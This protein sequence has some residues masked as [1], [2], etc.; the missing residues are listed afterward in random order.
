MKRFLSKA[1]DL[2]CFVGSPYLIAYNLLN[3]DV[4]PITTKGSES[5]VYAPAYYY[6]YTLGTQIGFALGVSL[7]CLGFLVKA[8]KK[9]SI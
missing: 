5:L 7:V 9:K 6:H 4:G 3:F 2:I 8:W 1:F